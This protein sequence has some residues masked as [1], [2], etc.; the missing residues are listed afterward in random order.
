VLESCIL[1]LETLSTVVV[2]HLI[3]EWLRESRKLAR[4]PFFK[5]WINLLKS[6][7]ALV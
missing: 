1:T 5:Q 7:D 6:V 3:V 4:V 2:C